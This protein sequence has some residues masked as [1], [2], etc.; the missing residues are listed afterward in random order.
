MLTD[1]RPKVTLGRKAYAYVIYLI[2]TIVVMFSLTILI[3]SLLVLGL[4]INPHG[5]GAC[6]GVASLGAGLVRRA[7]SI[8]NG[9][10]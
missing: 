7:L 5:F 8:M 3:G 2:G 6:L 4:E 9:K 10:P 1:R